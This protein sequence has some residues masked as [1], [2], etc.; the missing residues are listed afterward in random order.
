MVEGDGLENRCTAMYRGF[1][2]LLLRI[3]QEACFLTRVFGFILLRSLGFVLTR[4]FRTQHSDN[5]LD[6]IPSVLLVAEIVG[7]FRIG[8]LG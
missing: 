6:I 5:I 8:P 1:E 7:E 2:S 4:I 3:P